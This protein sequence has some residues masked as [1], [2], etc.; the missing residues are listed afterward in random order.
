[1]FKR[2]AAAWLLR[3]VVR[4]LDS[5]AASHEQQTRLLAR[6]AD[7]F[8]PQPLDLAQVDRATIKADTGV[9]Y[10]D[11]DELVAAEAFAARQYAH[12]GHTPD[13]DELLIHLADEKT[14]DLADRLRTRD[15]ELARLSEER[16]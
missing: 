1:M 11:A 16:R 14:R 9:S 12:T 3:R 6:L 15:D 8:A 7:R 13:D 4:S 5:L 2:V 10:L